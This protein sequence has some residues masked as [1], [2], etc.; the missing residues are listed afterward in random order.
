MRKLVRV[1][2]TADY[3]QSAI[4]EGARVTGKSGDRVN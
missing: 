1:F 3:D 2:L 4:G